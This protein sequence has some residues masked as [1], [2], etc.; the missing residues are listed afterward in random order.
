MQ[1]DTVDGLEMIVPFQ[2]LLPKEREERERDDQLEGFEWEQSSLR[3][4]EKK[5]KKPQSTCLSG[6]DPSMHGWGRVSRHVISLSLEE[7]VIQLILERQHHLKEA[8][9]HIQ[10][11]Y[12]PRTRTR[13]KQLLLS[14][15]HGILKG[16]ACKVFYVNSSNKY[17][18]HQL[19]H[20]PGSSLVPD[21]SEE[22]RQELIR[23]ARQLQQKSEQPGELQLLAVRDMLGLQKP[24]CCWQSVH[25]R[26]EE[27]TDE[28]TAIFIRR[29]L[30]LSHPLHQNSRVVQPFWGSSSWA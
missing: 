10:V 18:T 20:R 3:G 25:R 13:R 1:Y 11:E 2:R 30:L 14:L 6:R 26:R 22:R 9:D 29:L 15:R 27:T 7:D 17:I 24:V 8:S 21:H 16:K 19:H 4:K 5:E 12:V 28:R 23:L